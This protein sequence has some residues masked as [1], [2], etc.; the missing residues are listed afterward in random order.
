MATTKQASKEA[1]RGNNLSPRNMKAC[2][3]IISIALLQSVAEIVTHNTSK[4]SR[5]TLHE[6]SPHIPQKMPKRKRSS[7]TNEMLHMDIIVRRQTTK[8]SSTHAREATN[9]HQFPNSIINP[10]MFLSFASSP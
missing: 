6:F 5:K 7:S 10:T 8:V 1:K 2:H 4:C 3:N 9:C